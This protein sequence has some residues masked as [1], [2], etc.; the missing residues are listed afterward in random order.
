MSIL[1]PDFDYRN[2]GGFQIDDQFYLQLQAFGGGSGGGVQTVVGGTDIQVTGSDPTHPIVGVIPGSFVRDITAGSNITVTGT[3]EHPIVNAAAGGTSGGTVVGLTG[4][5]AGINVDN[6]DPVNPVVS[7]TGVTSVVAGSNV[8]ISGATGAVTINA[9]TAGVFPAYT[10]FVAVATATVDSG[11]SGTK[12]KH[13]TT[14]TSGGG[15]FTAAS[16]VYVPPT[17]GIYHCEW[18][19]LGPAPSYAFGD[20]Y[21]TDSHGNNWNSTQVPIQFGELGALRIGG[22]TLTRGSADVH[23][24]ASAPQGL[25]S[26]GGSY[27]RT[28]SVGG[29]YYSYLSMRL[30]SED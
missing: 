30:I 9:S 22:V 21:V 17:A 28:P 5:G 7:N 2:A 8:T 13:W 6:M 19:L 23:F 1:V 12:I 24:D 26:V 29:H 14:I 4:T 15:G 20:A 11:D 10:G 16:G 3:F 27:T 25:H 18:S